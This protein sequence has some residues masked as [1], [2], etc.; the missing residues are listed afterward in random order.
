MLVLI[1]YVFPWFLI[2]LVPIFTF[3]FWLVRYFRPTQRHIKRLDN[4]SR[5]PLFSHLSAT[6]QGLSTIA[7]FRKQDDFY[8]EFVTRLTTNSKFVA[9]P[10]FCMFQYTTRLSAEVE[11]RFNSVERLQQ[12]IKSTP[13]ED[14][15]GVDPPTNWPE[16]GQV[17]FCDVSARYR[18]GLETVLKS[19]SFSVA[20]QQHVGI[21]GRTG[22]G[23]S[24]L[25][26]VLYRLLELEAGQILIDGLD[27]STI[28][29]DMLRSRLSIIPQEP[30]LFVG[31]LRYNLDPFGVYA[32]EQIWT[33]LERAHMRD[34]IR[35]LPEKLDAPV[36]EN[37]NNFSVGERQLLCM[38]RAL[39]R[40]SRILVLDEAS[41]STDS[42]TDSLLQTTIR[43]SFAGC[44]VLTIAHR[45]N[46]VMDC[47]MIMLMDHGTYKQHCNGTYPPPA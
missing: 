13:H 31:T 45:L 14:F 18:A 17:E 40:N 25:T 35:R 2:A 26:Q 27:I 47:D 23:K 22:A 42:K 21:V 8:N 6:L 38:A 28:K 1:A 19:I 46:T 20:P 15:S 30:V 9:K 43:T 29:L 24:S 4:V 33:A 12:T 36:V 10:L 7:A 39:L 34:A 5:S 3:F 16:E 37:G 44:T 11:G 32:D 41:S